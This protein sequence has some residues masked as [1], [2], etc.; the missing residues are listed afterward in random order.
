MIE[1]MA[2]TS[3][4]TLVCGRIALLILQTFH[5]TMRPKSINELNSS[6]IENSI[7]KIKITLTKRE[8]LAIQLPSCSETEKVVKFEFSYR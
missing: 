1:R 7:R 8:R 5:Q 3:E 6:F 4:P 2:E